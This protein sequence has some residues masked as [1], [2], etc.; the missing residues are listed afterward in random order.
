MADN[1]WKTDGQY[2]SNF[3]DA[4]MQKVEQY[5][6]SQAILKKSVEIENKIKKLVA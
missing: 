5:Y 6:P 2:C 1:G 4:F 3:S